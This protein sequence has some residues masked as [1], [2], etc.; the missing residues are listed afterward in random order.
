MHAINSQLLSAT[1]WIIYLLKTVGIIGR[2]PFVP[3]VRS[4]Q[5]VL[6]WNGRVLRTGSGQNGPVHGSGPLSCHALRPA[7]TRGFGELWREKCT[8]APWTFPFRLARTSSFQLARTDRWAVESDLSLVMTWGCLISVI[9]R[10][11]CLN[12]TSHAHTHTHA[13]THR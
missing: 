5:S 7:K 2:L 10:G 4:D 12:Q 3:S 9:L 8:R 1:I 6:K 11:N 13:H